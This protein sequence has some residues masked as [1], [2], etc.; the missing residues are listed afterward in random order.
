MRDSEIVALYWER[1]EEA[2]LET[3]KKYGRYLKK[4]A[5]NVL[6]DFEDSEECVNDTYLKAW[7]SMPTQKPEFLSTY[8]GALTRRR[9][10]DLF[11]R[12]NSRRRIGSQ[13]AVALEELEDCIS[14]GNITEQEVDEHILREVINAWLKTISQEGRDVFIGR[15]YFHDSLE[16]I[17]GYCRFSVPK[18]KSMLHRLRLGLKTYLEEEGFYYE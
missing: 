17:A 5:F 6:A 1:D 13:Y 9:A 4:I 12:R 18:V 11:R 7:N 10:I 3:E 2:L 16:D 15:Y 8:L 14:A